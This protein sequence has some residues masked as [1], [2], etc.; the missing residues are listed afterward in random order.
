MND[1]MTATATAT[2]W[3]EVRP[4]RATD[5][6]RRRHHALC[7]T[8]GKRRFRD[9]HDAGLELRRLGH[10]RSSLDAQD[11][12][13]CIRVVRAFRCEHCR[14]WHLT[15]KPLQTRGPQ[16]TPRTL[17]LGIVPARFRTTTTDAVPHRAPAAA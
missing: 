2:T 16:R 5:R 11:L 10:Q 4:R 8:T 13:H 14:G 15:S 7:P 3:V 6:R 12:A 17:P 9:R 1:P